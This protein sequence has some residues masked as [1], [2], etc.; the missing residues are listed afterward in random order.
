M[1]YLKALTLF[2][3][4]MKKKSHQKCVKASETDEKVMVLGSKSH[5]IAYHP[6]FEHLNFWLFEI[7]C[8]TF[9]DN[10]QYCT[11]RNGDIKEG[12]AQFHHLKP[13]KVSSSKWPRFAPIILNSELRDGFCRRFLTNDSKPVKFWSIIA[14]CWG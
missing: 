12:F 11:C 10:N 7:K 2:F 14:T 9:S 1:F 13:Q 6:Y 4:G 8:T 5:A 3:T